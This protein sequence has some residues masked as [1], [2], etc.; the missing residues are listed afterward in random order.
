MCLGVPGQIVEVLDPEHGIV[1]IDVRGARRKASLQALPDGQTAEL[2]DWI[3]CHMGLALERID[4][5]EAQRIFEF[6]DAYGPR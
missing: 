3:L 6:G 5:A 2:G 4:E 1:E